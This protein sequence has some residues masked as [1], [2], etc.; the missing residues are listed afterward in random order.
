MIS[1]RQTLASID[2]AVTRARDTA[3]AVE[4]QIEAVNQKLAQQRQAQAEDYKELARLRLGQ[5]VDTNLVEHLDQSE[6]QVLAL[7]AQRQA[8]LTDLQ[9]QIQRAEA[10]L[11]TLESERA[12][13][14]ALVDGAAQAVD[15]AEARTQA[16]LDAE[17]AYQ[18]QRERARAA[19][20]KAAHADE[21]ATRSEAER[22]EKGASYRADPLF[23]YLWNRRFGQPDYKGWFLTRWLDAKVAR[24]IGF[25]DAR[26]NY[27]RLNEIPERLREHAA[28]LKAAAESE[29]GALKS[30]DETARI[31]DGI[32]ALDAR[33]ADQQAKLDAVDQR[34]AQAEADH[35]ELQARKALFARGEDKHTK[36][37]LEFLAAEFQRDDLMELRREALVTPFPEDDL[38]VARLLQRE[39][40]RRRFDSALQ[41][42]RESLA[43]HHRRLNE[44]EAL[45]IDFKRNRY[46]RA[47]STFGDDAMIAMMLGQFLNGV[48]DRQNLWRIL[49]EQQRY[50]PEQSDP[51]FGSGGFG[52][53]TVWGGGIGDLRDLGDIVGGFG[54][55]GARGGIGG[56]RLGG[57]RG[58][59]GGGFR[60]GGGF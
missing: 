39:D 5:L 29:F 23:M 51:R 38:V 56:G 50:R 46:D 43:Q 1:G 58:S 15:S 27:A 48:L 35:Q 57:G 16:R 30:L 37:A 12:A 22:E 10:G 13:Q 3:A 52:R 54:R 31:E 32:P 24:L 60:T 47:G 49:Q 53:G 2:Q 33:L 36:N 34:I 44:L 25:T 40:E 8:A 7:L 42:L 45:R 19:E 20:R 9:E 26:A 17:R 14:A 41:G 21:K 59:S 28:G 18:A 6:R 55:G 11:Q 4:S